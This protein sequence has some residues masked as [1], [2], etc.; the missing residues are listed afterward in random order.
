MKKLTLL[1][2]LALF[3]TSIGAQSPATD[4]QRQMEGLMKEV[5]AQQVQIA[6]NQAKIDAKLAALAE[7]IRVARI[8]SSRGGR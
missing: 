4:E 2:L 5:Q 8:Y 3:A 6:E 7:A 1:G